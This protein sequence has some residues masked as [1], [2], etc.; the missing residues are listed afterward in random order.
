MVAGVM[1]VVGWLGEM[2]VKDRR[3]LFRNFQ[4]SML[5]VLAFVVVIGGMVAG[6]YAKRPSSVDPPAVDSW[7]VYGMVVAGVVMLAGL[8]TLVYG[9]H[10]VVTRVRARRSAVVPRARVVGERVH[11]DDRDYE[12]LP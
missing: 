7:M 8:P 3:E 6:V 5:V 11:G 12:G 2:T 1:E 4:G 9:V 10:G